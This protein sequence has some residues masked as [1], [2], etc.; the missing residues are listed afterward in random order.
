MDFNWHWPDGSVI[1]A[2]AP[3][4][5]IFDC[6]TDGLLDTL[7]RVHS[8]VMR[9]PHSG[10]TISATPNEYG[11]DDPTII[12]DWTVEEALHAL[13]NAD[14]IIGHNIIKFDIPALQKVFPWFEP[15]GLIIDTL[16]CSRLL[17]S[18][19]ADHDLKQVRKGYPGKLVGSHSL[20]AWGYRLGV[21]KGEFGETSDW[22]FW[23]PEMQTYCEQDVEVTAKLYARIQKKDPAKKSLWIEHEFCKIIAMQ[24][25]HGFA[26][27]EA[28]AIKLYHQLVQRRM[29][30]ARDLQVAFPPVEK[31]EVFIPKVNNKQRGYVRGEPFTKKWMVEFNPSSRQM[32]AD[33]LQAMGWVP[34]EF[35][36]SGQPKIDETIL[37]ALP[38]PQAKV[39]AEHFLVEKRIGQ[40]AEGDQAWLKLV[41][42]GRIHG[43]VNTNGA[44]TGRCTH[45][46]P[47][48]A[49]VPKVGSPYGAECRALFSTTSRWVLVGADLSGLELRCLA[50]FMAL[51]DDGEFG[52]ILIEADAHWTNVQALDLTQEARDD[53][54]PLHILYRNG[55]KTFIYAFLY[56]AGD[57]KIGSVVYDI[58]V[59]ARKKGLPYRHLADKYFKGS[60]EPDK[61][62]LKAAGKKLKKSFLQR[63]PALR[64]LREVVE[65]KVLGFVRKERPL[66]VNPVYAGN[67]RQDSA[68]QWWFKDG[69]GGVLVGLDGRKLHIRSSHAA[70]NTLLQSAGALISKVAMIFAYRELSTRGYIFGK[71]YGFVAHIHDEIQTECRP[72]IADEVGQ[73]VVQAMRDAGAFFAFSCPIDGEFKIGNNWKETH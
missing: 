1:D 61:E 20:K 6:E 13:M 72:E 38:Y 7:T 50:H 62:Q 49:Q 30:I 12:T 40:L 63:T 41:R 48:V 35:T 45:S 2:P 18:D 64:R 54:K 27:N 65:L 19:I 58:M 26:F 22:Q 51:F 60:E 4:T 16:V 17:W 37:Q 59:E 34:Q 53:H 68:K 66:I 70:L 36:P 57:E 69:P 31:T 73:I 11:S 42:K 52:R 8:L 39:L 29:E 44:V 32:I 33:R 10:F 3:S 25:R 21:L 43:S 14:V 9:D 56:G 24:E 28:E 5:Y 23:S 55:S 67:W 46:G 15:K 71:D 47:N